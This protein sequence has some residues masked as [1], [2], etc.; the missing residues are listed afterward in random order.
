MGINLRRK[1]PKKSKKTT[2]RKKKNKYIWA[3]GRRKTATA[4]IKLYS[5]KGELLVNEKQ[6][7][8]YFPGEV[9]EVLYS[10]P[11]RTTNLL[12]KVS[13]TFKVT[14]SGKNAQLW[15]VIHALSR[16]INK[17]D[18]EK[19]HEVLKKKGFLSRDPR[20]RERRKPGYAQK[21]RAKKQSPKR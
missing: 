2:S 21:A 19:Y 6:I 13:A 7:G 18:E 1:V 14:G 8:E 15:A 17:L 20:M 5:K 3:V 12:G 4:T 16:A 10:E 11:L 9:D